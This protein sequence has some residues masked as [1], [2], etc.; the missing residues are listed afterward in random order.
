MSQL[1]QPQRLEMYR[2]MRM[3]RIVEERLVNLYRQGKIVGGLYR[4]LGQEATSVGSAFAL[5]P[6]DILSPLIRNLGSVLVRGFA[7]RDLFAQ[8]LARGTSPSRGK[9][10][11]LHFA[12]LERGVI[13]PISM[14]GELV[15]IMAGVALAARMQRKKIVCLTYIGDGATSTGPFHEGMNFAAVQKLPLV[16]VG[17]NN[18]W[19]YSTPITRQMAC[20]SL[21]DRAK[22]YGIPSATVDGNDVEAVHSATREAVARARDGGGVTFL[23]AVTYRMKGH[24][25]HDAQEYVD[26]RELDAWRKKDP[27]DRYRAQ[28]IADAVATEGGLRQIDDEVAAG[29]DEDLRSAESA[30]FPE[31]SEA[32]H[33]VYA[34]RPAEDARSMLRLADGAAK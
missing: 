14:L 1:T 2:F 4:S 23:E 18:H 19:A 28:L 30:P 22:A 20:N 17:E 13:G 9:D 7:P 6:G 21:S 34:E 32:L 27:I 16:V 25:E 5:E 33:G 26:P 31:P 29:V 15:P 3:N 11:T 10:G 24:A 8:Y 12:S